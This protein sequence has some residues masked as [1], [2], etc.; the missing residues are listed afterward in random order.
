MRNP[1]SKDICDKKK[2]TRPRPTATWVL[3]ALALTERLNV[4]SRD[5]VEPKEPFCQEALDNLVTLLPLG[6]PRGRL[7]TMT[8]A[9]GGR[10]QLSA[11][12]NWTTLDDDDT[13]AHPQ[14]PTPPPTTMTH[15]G[16]QD[17]KATVCRNE[18]PP[19]NRGG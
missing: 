9:L 16:D 12:A 5:T 2:K 7:S 13:T 17:G 15:A 1:S 8:R 19:W 4:K 11:P 18:M 6:A 14:P 3:N 10:N